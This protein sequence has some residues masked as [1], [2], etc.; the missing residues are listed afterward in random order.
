LG[1]EGD[2]VVGCTLDEVLSDGILDTIGGACVLEI[3]GGG[4]TDRTIYLLRAEPPSSESCPL[5]HRER[6]IVALLADGYAALNIAARLGLSHA[7]IRNHI[8]NIL[9][10]LGVHSQVEAVSLSLR[11]GWVGRFDVESAPALAA[12]A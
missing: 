8:Q 3:P 12:S 6:G 5:S 10:K 2:A 9:R 11:R 1:V 7:T 4:R